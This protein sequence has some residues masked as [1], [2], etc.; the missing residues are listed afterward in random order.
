MSD[1]FNTVENGDKQSEAALN[2]A[3]QSRP[4]SQQNADDGPVSVSVSAMY[5]AGLDF[6][7]SR[8]VILVLEQGGPFVN[9]NVYIKK[10]PTPIDGITYPE[11]FKVMGPIID[12]EDLERLD[13]VYADMPP[14]I[15]DFWGPLVNPRLANNSELLSHSEKLL[16]IERLKANKIIPELLNYGLTH[17]PSEHGVF[18]KRAESPNAY[19]PAKEWFPQKIQNELTFDD[20][21]ILFPPAEREI[22]KLFLGRIGCGRNNS[23]PPNSD[24]PI[25]HTARMALVVLGKEAGLGKST[26]SNSIMSALLKVGFTV[27]TF[28]ETKERFGIKKIAY[29]DVCYKDD[30]SIDGLM[31]FLKAEE[32]KILISNGLISTEQ[33]FQEAETVIPKCS[34]LINSNSWSSSFAYDLDS[35]IQSRIKTVTTY[36]GI[37]LRKLQRSKALQGCEDL[38]PFYAL[39]WLA[40]KYGCSIDTIILWALRLASDEFYSCITDT[41]QD[42][43]INPLEDRVINLTSRLR[44]RFK[45][46]VLNSMVSAMALSKTIFDKLR[47]KSY[48]TLPEFS[49]RLFFEMIKDFYFI[50]V[51][52]C[53]LDLCSVLKTEW[54]NDGRKTVHPYQSLR[55]LKLYTVKH[56]LD[57]ATDHYSDFLNGG[58]IPT[59]EADILKK[60]SSFILFRDGFKLGG[61]I[62][63]TIDAINNVAYQIEDIG[64]LADTLIT[65]LNETDKARL[66][67]YAN[68]KV[69]VFDDWT[70]IIEYTPT[71]AEAIRSEARE[72]LLAS[73]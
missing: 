9:H 34:I 64:K 71:N 36:S 31:A 46:D 11:W 8:G 56:A 41:S 40:N 14:A 43:S 6:F 67:G 20:V 69:K 2:T 53:G 58:N 57:W 68:N 10:L 61:G 62:G 24:K 21:F 48:P 18:G 47:G 7:Q 19:I 25:K 38:R 66:I 23:L 52:P 22:F 16:R 49:F 33:K 28:R 54:E 55:D 39:P 30:V 17:A 27:E 50:A 3:E 35:G 42:P 29:A 4:Q 72:K 13:A 45:N 51:D 59:S 26:I 65:H 12:P 5:K 60:F 63:Y 44:Y 37:E 1:F 73:R 70:N 15:N 32:T